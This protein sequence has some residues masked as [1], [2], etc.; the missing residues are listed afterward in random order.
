M[1]GKLERIF[2]PVTINSLRL[3]NR[4]VMPP[5]ATGYG[6]KDGSVSER[7]IRYLERRARGGV[8]LVI[9]EICAVDPRGKGFP[10][11]IGAWS[12]DHIP[13][14]AALAGAV[15]AAGAA[16]ALQLHHA[17]RETMKDFTGAMPEAPSDVP[18]AILNQPCEAMSVARIHEV[19]R[20]YAEAA[21]RAR[22]AGFDA[23][24]VHGAHGYLVCQFLSPFSNKRTDEYGGSDEN[25]ARFAIEVLR[26]IRA[27]VGPGFPVIMRVSSDEL[28]R[29]GYDLRYMKWLAPRLVE[30]GADA[31]HVSLGVY[32]TPGGL[33]IA[34]SD[35][36]EGF[37]LFRAREIKE[38][39]TVPVIGVGRITDPR[40]ADAA[41]ERG[42]ADLISFGRQLLADPD[43]LVKA[44]S[45]AYD[46]I[47][48]CLSCNQGC[49]DR[50]NFEMRTATC[51]VNPDCGYEYRRT[52]EKAPA[53]KEVWVIGAGP[54]GLSAAL[55]AAARG[56]RVTVFEREAEPGGQ[57]IPASKPPHKEGLAKW[58]RWA[59]RMAGK[60]GVAIRYGTEVTGE[61]IA[62]GT[63][64]AVILATGALPSVSD[65]PGI[66]G[67]IVREARD[68]LTGKSEIISPAVVL[69]AGYVGMETADFLMERGVTVTVLEMSAAP[70]VPPFT[71]HGYW[72]HRRLKKGGRLVLGARVTSIGADCVR[73][74]LEGKEQSEP[75][76]MVVTA[77]GARSEQVLEEAVKKSG[78]ACVT[79][80]DAVRPRRLIEAVHEGAGAG[81]EI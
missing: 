63:P 3:K 25:R 73:Y 20:A 24:E 81:R 32:S 14:L 68:V 30:A 38:A 22:D 66:D 69:G 67:V 72:L 23:V 75:A 29:G 61:M 65:I 57:L 78:L 51:T 44:Q 39:V 76:A 35:M 6:N 62:A 48:W 45:G 28:I 56:H 80:G 55:E 54:A 1:S 33:T 40:T 71:A 52:G 50:L 53:A 18:S 27:L 43:V 58:T 26:A 7:L 9:T 19:A 37:N 49:I 31:L 36:E 70:P 42:D 59:N 4:A 60:A 21:R 34:S 74:E 13:G 12:D 41:I 8:G 79:V 5:M 11:E 15:H 2:S 10:A 47:R 64:E 77:L 16:T 17:G 46:D